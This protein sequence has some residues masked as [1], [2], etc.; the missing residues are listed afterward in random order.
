MEENFCDELRD[1]LE[2][3]EADDLVHWF[4]KV[5]NYLDK[6]K[7]SDGKKKW[8]KLTKL[9]RHNPKNVLSAMEHFNDFLAT[10]DLNRNF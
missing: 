7:K 6:Q 10:Y 9:F 1:I 4:V 3:S 2:D 8:K 5:S